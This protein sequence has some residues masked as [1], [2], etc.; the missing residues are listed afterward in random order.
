[1]LGAV[2]R[3]AMIVGALE[4]AMERTVNYASDRVQFGKSIGRNQAIQQQLALMASDT[5]AA[6]VAALVA[7]SDAP[8]VGNNDSSAAYFSAAVAKVRS[9]EAATRKCYEINSCVRKCLLGCSLV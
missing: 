2:A 7:F 1:M 3:S 4:S 5:A 9:G 8:G 6:R